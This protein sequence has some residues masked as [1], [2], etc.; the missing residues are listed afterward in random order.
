MKQYK[1]SNKITVVSKD[2]G[3]KWCF[4]T[5]TF[6]FLK[7][8]WIVGIVVFLLTYSSGE[9]TTLVYVYLFFVAVFCFCIFSSE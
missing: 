7:T 6:L 3:G 2:T 4:I 1:T 8:C 9:C 5:I